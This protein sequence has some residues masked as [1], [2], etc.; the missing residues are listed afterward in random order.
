VSSTGSLSEGDRRSRARERPAMEAEVRGRGRG[1][2]AA[3]LS[4]KVTEA[5]GQPVKT[6]KG[7]EPK[8]RCAG[9]CYPARTCILPLLTSRSQGHASI[10]V[11]SD[12]L[13]GN[14]LWYQ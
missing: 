14:L 8:C 4:L 2:D 10:T 3:V 13:S 12:W 11:V 1:S 7:L 6:G 9:N 5:H